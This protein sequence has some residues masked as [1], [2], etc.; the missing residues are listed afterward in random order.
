MRVKTRSE[1]QAALMETLKYHVTMLHLQKTN[2]A[3]FEFLV[4]KVIPLIRLICPGLEQ[5]W[6]TAK[7]N[8]VEQCEKLEKMALSEAEQVFELLNQRLA[9]AELLEDESIKQCLCTIESALKA[10]SQ[11][12]KTAVVIP[13]RVEVVYGSLVNL[14]YAILKLGFKDLIQD[15]ADVRYSDNLREWIIDIFSMVP[16]RHKLIELQDMFSWTSRIKSPVWV[17][18]ENLF[19]IEW[20]WKLSRDF[21]RKKELH[22]ENPKD[23]KR[24]AQL[25][26]FHSLAFDVKSIQK[27]RKQKNISFCDRDRISKNLELVLSEVYSQ[28]DYTSELSMFVIPYAIELT[29]EENDVRLYLIVK[30]TQEIKQ[31]CHLHTFQDLDSN[32]R[33]KFI[34]DLLANPNILIT[35]DPESATGI[36]AKQYL[37]KIGINGVLDKLFIIRKTAHGATLRN[38]CVPLVDE[39]EV[40]LKRLSR[41]IQ[42]LETIKWKRVNLK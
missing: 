8:Y 7:V 39:S 6:I 26:M 19:Q 41:H 15:Y 35:M 20:S 37:E 34:N 13:S 31:V 18:W 10:Q 32:I 3:F 29:M 11:D 40:T 4:V 2:Y 23:C 17:A 25:L 28:S 22:Y 42:N 14:C 12:E 33:Y 9:K 16:S 30:W 21:F 36:N 24:S 1:S 5:Q 27:R 38:K